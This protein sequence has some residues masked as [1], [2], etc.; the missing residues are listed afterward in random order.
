MAIIYKSSGPDSHLSH[1]FY[2]TSGKQDD[3]C[4]LLVDIIC[5]KSDRIVIVSLLVYTS[6]TT[7]K[8]HLI[9]QRVCNSPQTDNLLRC[10]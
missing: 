3:N 6:Y 7:Q 8:V 10:G 2:G 5:V 9:S 1:Q 4:V